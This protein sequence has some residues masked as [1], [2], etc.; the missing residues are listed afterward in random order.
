MRLIP[1]VT[2][3]SVLIALS[4]CT[5][6]HM[7]QGAKAGRVVS[8][9]PS[10]CEQPGEVGVAVKERVGFYDRDRLRVR[11]EVGILARNE[12]PGLGGNVVQPLD[13]FED[14]TQRFSVW[15]CG[16]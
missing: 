9:T 4:G 5:W 8:S 13:G 3:V 6:V 14:G 10:R 7:A 12:A 16:G 2:A 11:D 15:R 1:A